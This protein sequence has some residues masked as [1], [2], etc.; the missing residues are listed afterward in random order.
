MLELLKQLYATEKRLRDKL[1]SGRLD[2]DSFTATRAVAMA[3]ILEEIGGWLRSKAGAFPPKTMIG[4]AVSYALGEFPKAS[5][6]VDHA[7]LRPDTNLVENQ[8]RPFVVGRKGWLFMD[9]PSGAAAS[10]AFYGIIA[11]ARLNGH[12]PLR[13]LTYVFDAIAR[14]GY[15]DQVDDLL[16]YTLDPQALLPVKT[17]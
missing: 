17:G 3:P 9:S 11:T 10:A 14:R 4:Q 1:D 2:D 12:E 13:Y 6:F 8:I 7:L 16:P 5:R 15:D